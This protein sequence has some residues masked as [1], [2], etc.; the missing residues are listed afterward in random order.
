[1]LIFKQHSKGFQLSFQGCGWQC[2]WEKL[3]RDLP[4]VGM[5]SRRQRTQGSSRQK[6]A[7]IKTNTWIHH[8]WRDIQAVFQFFKILFPK[9]EKKRRISLKDGGLDS[10]QVGKTWECVHQIRRGFVSVNMRKHFFKGSCEGKVRTISLRLW[11]NKQKYSVLK[12]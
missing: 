4:F 10:Q 7:C 2:W 8:L 11:E 5:G 3:W 12:V 9:E 1:M 6:P